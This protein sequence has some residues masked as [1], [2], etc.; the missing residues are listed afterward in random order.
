MAADNDTAVLQVVFIDSEVPDLQDLLNGIENPLRSL[1]DSIR[2][3][4]AWRE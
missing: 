3:L 4:K 1:Q 2:P